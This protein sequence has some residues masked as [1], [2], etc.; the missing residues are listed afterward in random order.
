MYDFIQNFWCIYFCNF[1]NKFHLSDIK[2]TN[3]IML[4]NS[5]T[6]EWYKLFTKD[7]VLSYDCT[8]S[9]ILREV[10]KQ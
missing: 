4:H 6:P 2:K 10:I 8:M 9:N 3:M 1:N 5:W 7:Q